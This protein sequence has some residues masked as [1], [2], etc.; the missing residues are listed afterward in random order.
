VDTLNQQCRDAFATPDNASRTDAIL[1]A[2]SKSESIERQ[3]M[4]G[5]EN[6]RPHHDRLE[7]AMEAVNAFL[8][9][10]DYVVDVF[11]STMNQVFTGLKSVGADADT[12]MGITTNSEGAI[13]AVKKQLQGP[14]SEAL[15]TLSHVETQQELVDASYQRLRSLGDLLH[16]WNISWQAQAGK[17]AETQST[18][19]WCAKSMSF[20][21]Q[22]WPTATA[23]SMAEVQKK[24]FIPREKIRS[25]FAILPGYLRALGPH[26]GHGWWNFGQ[27]T[28]HDFLTIRRRNDQR[29]PT[30]K[31][32][33]IQTLQQTQGSPLPDIQ[34]RH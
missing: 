9:A 32:R 14:R 21:V 1:L 12:I 17:Y 8:N 18:T 25:L 34:L 26:Q 20:Y 27:N 7:E 4:G 3:A 28:Q 11:E 15:R 10:V 30:R 5:T 29:R 24:K 31:R 22:D 6:L 2:L 16:H 19:A 13:S 23:K 33:G